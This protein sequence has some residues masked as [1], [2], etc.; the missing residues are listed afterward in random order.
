MVAFSGA[1]V[2]GVCFSQKNKVL[3]RMCAR[4]NLRSDGFPGPVVGTACSGACWVSDRITKKW[5]E[6]NVTWECPK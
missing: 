2:F 4:H 3:R 5:I 6:K 1:L